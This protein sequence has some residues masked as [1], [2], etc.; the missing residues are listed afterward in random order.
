MA[1]KVLYIILKKKEKNKEKV[2]QLCFIIWND[3]DNDYIIYGQFTII[4]QYVK[5]F[6]E[7]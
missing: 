7:Q 6:K 2:L 3:F 4:Y 5:R 1:I